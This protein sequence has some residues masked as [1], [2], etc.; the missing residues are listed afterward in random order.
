MGGGGVRGGAVRTQRV[1]GGGG[2][3]RVVKRH[4]DATAMMPPHSNRTKPIAERTDL[5]E[6]DIVEVLGVGDLEAAHAVRVPP[7]LEMPVERA[8][9][10][11]RHVAADLALVPGCGG[12]GGGGG[13]GGHGGCI[14]A[15][16]MIDALTHV[17][18][19]HT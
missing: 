19:E 4:E 13:G 9:A 8:A 11:I 6:G 15:G 1:G 16:V 10:P 7:L 3:E 18:N 2:G 14:G 12:G 5:D 17:I